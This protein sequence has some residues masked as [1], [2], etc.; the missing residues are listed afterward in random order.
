[1]VKIIRTSHQIKIIPVKSQDEARLKIVN[2]VNNF[3]KSGIK[4]YS[5]LLQP[6]KE[7]K[8]AKNCTKNNPDIIFTKADKGNVTVALTL[9]GAH[10]SGASTPDIIVII[11]VFG[12]ADYESEVRFSK[13]K[14][15][16]PIWRSKL[17]KKGK[18]MLNLGYKGFWDR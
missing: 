17:S 11:T 12:V 14:M 16:D 5:K 13:S 3:Y 8:E 1:M 9:S 15:A 2:C 18:L 4:P 6:L 7:I 10:F